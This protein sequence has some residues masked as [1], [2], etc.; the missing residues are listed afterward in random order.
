LNAATDAHESWAKNDSNF[1]GIDLSP[2]SVAMS[3]RRFQL[4]GYPGSFVLG[5]ARKLPF[6][7]GSFDFA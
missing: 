1:T 4:F 7:D 6:E 2:M 5:D 3:S